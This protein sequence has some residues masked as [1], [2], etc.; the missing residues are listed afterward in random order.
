MAT[1]PRLLNGY[2]HTPMTRPPSTGRQVSGITGTVPTCRLV[3]YQA[4]PPRTS[5]VS[6]V[7]QLA[8]RYPKLGMSAKLSAR[9]ATRLQPAAHVNDDCRSDALSA[10][11]KALFTKPS[12]R[13]SESIRSAGSD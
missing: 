4:T 9:F 13:P 1:P 7:A 12:A 6:T 2:T 11:L 8:P 10:P 3:R 5:S